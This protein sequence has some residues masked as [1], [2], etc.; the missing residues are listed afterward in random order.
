VK[1]PLVS[2]CM[3][4]YNYGRY[5]GEAIE[6]VLQQDFDNYELIIVDDGSVDDT[7][8]IVARF[9]SRNRNIRYYKNAENI[10]MVNNWNLCLDKS[11]G[12]YIKYLFA[13]DKFA[14]NTALRVMCDA[15]E[16]N[17]S[18]IM[19]CSARIVIDEKSVPKKVWSFLDSDTLA[20]G[21]KLSK[22]CIMEQRNII[23]EPTA[24][25]FRR[26]EGMIGFDPLFRQL[27]DLE[28][29]LRLLRHG[30]MVF[31]RRPLVSFRQHP[32]Q[33]SEVNSKTM[34]AIHE[35]D[36]ISRSYFAA[37]TRKCNLFTRCY[38]CYTY[39]YKVWKASLN[40]CISKSESE[41]IVTEKKY[42]Y[43]IYLIMPIYKII[44]PIAKYI[45][46]LNRGNL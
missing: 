43:L 1:E 6:S 18:A 7:D 21:W 34:V 38:V 45:I 28:M 39:L 20:D 42:H 5:I 14:D 13:D 24:V 46:K 26:T 10:G 16:K 41:S 23:G 12:R 27:V 19:V 3:P 22:Q 11:S 8:E 37:A 9:T 33:Q 30:D 44:N 17:S 25:M 31:L 36:R 32:E 2:I 35:M 4:T 15:L 29:W 40:G